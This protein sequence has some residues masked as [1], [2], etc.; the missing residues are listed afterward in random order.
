MEAEQIIDAY[1]SDRVPCSDQDAI[2]YY[3]ETYGGDK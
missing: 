2:Q 1:Q 3:L